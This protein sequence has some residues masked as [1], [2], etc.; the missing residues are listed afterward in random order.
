M[1]GFAWRCLHH[2]VAADVDTQHVGAA[3]RPLETR[4]PGEAVDGGDYL[5]D[6]SGVVLG[7]LLRLGKRLGFLD[8]LVA[9]ASAPPKSLRNASSC[10]TPTLSPRAWRPRRPKRAAPRAPARRRG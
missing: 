8:D 3:E 5:P 9:H 10:G 4:L 6:T 1:S 2:P 7:E